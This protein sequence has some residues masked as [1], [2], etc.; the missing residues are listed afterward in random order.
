MMEAP[1]ANT[2]EA[3]RCAALIGPY[4]SGKTTLREALLHASGSTSRRG[5]VRDGNSVGDH[6]P[7]ARA[8]QMST[9][10]NVANATFLGDPWTILDCPGSVE[11]LHEAQAATLVAD[12]VVV[13]CEPEV[14]RAITVSALLHF[15]A[16]HNIP[17]MLVIN[18][19][20]AANARVRAVLA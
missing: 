12:I 16:R 11:L 4:L 2:S 20:D 15:L 5:S 6:A 18:K 8:R 19:L 14:E 10:L 7:E 9:E 3:P 17:H 13:V 1:M